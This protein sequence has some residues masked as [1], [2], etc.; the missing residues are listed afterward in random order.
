MDATERERI[1]SDAYLGGC[2]CA[3]A[4]IGAFCE[5]MGLPRQQ[6]YR[7]MEG[8]GGGFGGKQEV[9]GAFSAAT[10]AISCAYASGSE[11][12]D[13]KLETYEKVREA[14][15]AFEDEFGSIRCIEILGGGKPQPFKCDDKVRCAVRVACR[16]IDGAE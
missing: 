1:A 4:V 16:T 8:F 7:I 12:A 10:A 15:E 14:A 11:D 2:T 9:C 13:T 6:A 5:D 3:Q